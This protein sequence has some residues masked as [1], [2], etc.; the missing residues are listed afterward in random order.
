L[1]HVEKNIN[2]RIVVGEDWNLVRIPEDRAELEGEPRKNDYE[3]KLTNDGIDV[4]TRLGKFKS[5]KEESGIVKD[6][7]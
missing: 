6:S 4:A 5:L 3:Y 7:K 2:D 1:R